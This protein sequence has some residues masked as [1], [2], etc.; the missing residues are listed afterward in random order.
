MVSL[1]T[2]TDFTDLFKMIHS[3][4]LIVSQ[5]LLLKFHLCTNDSDIEARFAELS[6]DFYKAAE[7]KMKVIKKTVL[8]HALQQF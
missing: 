4:P 7:D 8:A 6:G 3:L 2:Y 1:Y 5:Q